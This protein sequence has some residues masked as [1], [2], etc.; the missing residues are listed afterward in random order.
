[1][2]DPA[3]WKRYR[4]GTAGTLWVDRRG[5][6]QFRQL[7]RLP[8]NLANPMWVEGRIFFLSDHE[9]TANLYSTTPSGRPLRRHT[10]HQDFYARFPSSDGARIVYHAGADLWAYDPSE[11]ATRRLAVQTSGSRSQRNRRF[12]DPTA[13]LERFHLHPEGH[14]IALVSRGGVFTM[15]LWEGAPLRH[16][17]PSRFRLRLAAW[18]SDGKRIVAVTDEEGEEGLVVMNSDGSGR[19]RKIRGDFGRPLS[20]D[21]APGGSS[22]VALTNQRQELMVVD[23]AKGETKLIHQSPWDR[24]AGHAWSPDGGWLAFA[25]FETHR[26]SSLYL[27]EVDSWHVEPLTRPDFVDASPSFDPEGRYLYFLSWRVFDPVEDE[28]FFE[29]GFPKGAKPYLLTLRKDLASPF[30]AVSRSPRAPGS[31]V[32]GETEKEKAAETPAKVRI[33]LEGIA[34]RVVELPVPEARYRKVLGAAGRVF[35]SS[36]PVQGSI[37]GPDPIPKPPTGVLEAYDFGSERVERVMDG[38]SDFGVSADGKVI[39]IRATSKIRVV[40]VAFKEPDNQKKE[41]AGRESG[42]LDLE[43]VKVEVVP[44]LEWRQM[45]REAWRLQRDQFWTETMADVDWQEVHDR[46]LPLVD[47]VGSRAEFSDLLWELQGELGTS[48][49]YELG[50]DYR[51]EPKWFLGFLG[52]DLRWADEARSWTVERIPSGDGWDPIASSPLGRPGV[53]VREGDSIVAVEGMPTSKRRSPHQLLVHKAGSGV[54]LTVRTPGSRRR[55]VTVETLKSE[56]PLR[57]RDW[58]ETNRSYVHETTQGAVGYLHIPDMGASGFGEFHRY[59]RAEVGRTGLIVDVRSNTGGNVSQLLLEKLARRRLGYDVSRW[60]RPESW[61]V[62][63]PMGPMAAITDEYSG[64]DGDIFSHVFKLMGL[65]PLIGKRTWGGVIGIWARH[66]LVDGTITTQP[67]F[68]S[69]FQDVEW[70]LENYGTDP[71]IEVEILPQDHAAG[72]DTQL[73]RAVA[74]VMKLIRRTKPAIPQFAPVPSLRPPRLGP[75]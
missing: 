9:G 51:P 68:A 37:G 29:R 63:A 54:H 4:G 49:A 21:P 1:V 7:I 24:I 22:L 25:A 41:E 43:R 18:M 69:W 8:G 14:S 66:A 30:A 60:Q 31:P 2:A 42:Y 10:H 35:F 26:S 67:E 11:D 52:A 13:N 65:G 33:D 59:F 44:G 72:R 36:I 40:P 75:G 58:V 16:G 73:E 64:S 17:A 61:P 12:S 3:R 38:I 62:D 6:G 32:G 55:D 5:D 39:A 45:F 48:H 19:P 47:R 57:Y 71:D 34:E 15:P 74:E 20:L 56:L 27:C 50:G 28:L 46:Y 70:G 53:G 23:V